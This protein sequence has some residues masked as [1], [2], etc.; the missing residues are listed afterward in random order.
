MNSHNQ[1]IG[2]GKFAALVTSSADQ[3]YFIYGHWL[4]A[5]LPASIGESIIV[6]NDA[7]VHA[8]EL[9]VSSSG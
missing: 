1:G 2:R 5:E 6:L 8:P 3:Q 9:V 4:G 7:L